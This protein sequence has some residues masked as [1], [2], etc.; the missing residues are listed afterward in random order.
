[1][2]VRLR[3]HVAGNL[4]SAEPYLTWDLGP[5]SFTTDNYRSFP[6]NFQVWLKS[7]WP[8]PHTRSVLHVLLPYHAVLELLV[9]VVYHY[10]MRVWAIDHTKC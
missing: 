5:T 8:A 9:F 10:T 7:K 6:R 3:G 1:M 4:V 2:D